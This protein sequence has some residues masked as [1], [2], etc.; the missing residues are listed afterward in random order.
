MLFFSVSLC[1]C[2]Q[3]NGGRIVIHFVPLI[4][5]FEVEIDHK[6]AIHVFLA[7][8]IQ[9]YSFGNSYAHGEF[10]HDAYKK[11]YMEY[12]DFKKVFQ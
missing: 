11:T 4:N 3:S 6:V 5:P 1:Y 2:I 9:H 10:Y 8:H 12:E 7:T